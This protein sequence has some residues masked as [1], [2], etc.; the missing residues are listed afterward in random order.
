[1]KGEE[2]EASVTGEMNMLGNNSVISGNDRYTTKYVCMF[3]RV[4]HVRIF[5]PVIRILRCR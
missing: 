2:D 5:G 1:M 3:V 4:L